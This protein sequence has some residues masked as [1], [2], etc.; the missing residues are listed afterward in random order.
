MA[1]FAANA[2]VCGLCA[3]TER[4]SHGDF[5]QRMASPVGIGLLAAARF[6]HRSPEH[7]HEARVRM[8]VTVNPLPCLVFDL[9]KQ[10]STDPAPAQN[11]AMREVLQRTR[12]SGR[13]IIVRWR[14][15][16]RSAAI[17]GSIS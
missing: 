12:H 14:L 4:T 1:V 6:G 15:S 3:I 8:D 11:L 7:G 2:I 10:Q 17:G 9:R 5:R 13:N 16:A